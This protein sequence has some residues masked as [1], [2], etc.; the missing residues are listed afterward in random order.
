LTEKGL[1]QESSSTEN[2]GKTCTGTGS[3]VGRAASEGG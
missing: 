3:S 1:Q 2:S